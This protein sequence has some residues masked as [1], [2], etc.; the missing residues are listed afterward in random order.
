[1][2]QRSV[3]LSTLAILMLSFAPVRAAGQ[4]NPSAPDQQNPNAPGQ[5]SQPSQVDKGANPT[6]GKKVEREIKTALSQDPHVAKSKLQVQDTGKEI[7]LS[8]TV[9]T[10]E[11]KAQAEQIA[12]QHA[13]GKKVTNRIK[14]NPNVHPGPGL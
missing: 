3:F 12:T 14:V 7:I 10:A 13:N 9:A 6:A 4:A 1:M 8:G 2:T 11:D 5:Q